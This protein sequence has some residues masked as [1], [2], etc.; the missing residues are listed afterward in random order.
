MQDLRR[1]IKAKKI[2]S[3]WIWDGLGLN[4]GRL[5]DGLGRLLGSFWCFSVVSW[6]FKIEFLGSIGPRWPWIDLGSI[7]EGFGQGFGR[8]WE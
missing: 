3:K 7:L 8:A 4:L 2:A 1:K 6:P 5:W